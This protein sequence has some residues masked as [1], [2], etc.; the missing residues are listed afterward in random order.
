MAK[1]GFIFGTVG[2]PLSTPPRPGG[3]VGGIF[4]GWLGDRLGRRPTLMLTILMYSLFS[5]LTCFADRL[6]EVGALRFLVAMGVG[7][8]WAVGAALVAEVFPREARA[9]AS[10]IFHA[11]SNVGTW[12]TALAGRAVGAQWRYAYII[13]LLP[14]LLILWVRAWV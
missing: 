2:A 1:S 3:T 7:G 13:G 5:G 10:G 8:E 11:S 4:F 6:W 9:H 14:A 12:L